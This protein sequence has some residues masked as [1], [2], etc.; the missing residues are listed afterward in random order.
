MTAPRIHRV[1]TLDLPVRPF[2][3]PLA[4]E[5]AADI[6]AHFA[7]RQAE[8][9]Q[10]WNGRVLLGRKPV[11]SGDCFHAEAFE[12]S[13][14]SFLAW[15]DWGLPDKEVFDGFGMGALRCSDGAFVL[16]EMGSQNATAGRVYFPSGTPDPSDVRDGRLDIAGSVVREMQEETGLTPADY[17]AEAHWDVVVMGPI[18]AMIRILHVAVTG[19]A[20]RQ[21]IEANLAGQKQPELARIHLARGPRDLTSSMP[22]FVTAWLERQFSGGDRS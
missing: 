1:T 12:T 19:E 4:A 2:S 3:W 10:M 16:G 5:R 11:F 8:K 18:I 22:R 21:R 9:P 17:R 6:D 15:R 7:A 20:L 14:A 13:F